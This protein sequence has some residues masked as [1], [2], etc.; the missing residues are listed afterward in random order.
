MTSF[1]S[2]PVALFPKEYALYA[3]RLLLDKHEAAKPPMLL[4]QQKVVDNIFFLIKK[5]PKRKFWQA[6]ELLK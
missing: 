4:I 3:F 6:G 1:L 2:N 5:G